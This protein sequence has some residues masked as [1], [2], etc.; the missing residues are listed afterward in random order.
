MVHQRQNAHRG[1]TGFDDR[2]THESAGRAESR[3]HEAIARCRWTF[4]GRASPAR[5]ASRQQ[6]GRR[7]P[8]ACMPGT[9]QSLRFRPACRI[10]RFVAAQG[11]V[12]KGRCPISRVRYF[13]RPQRAPHAREVRRVPDFFVPQKF[14]PS[15]DG[16][17]GEV[18]HRSFTRRMP[19]RRR[20]CRVSAQKRPA[21]VAI[22][23]ADH[24]APMSPSVAASARTF[25]A[26]SLSELQFLPRA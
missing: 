2:P 10:R 25:F 11:R 24:V 3:V 13:Y 14:G 15:A 6:R 22:A 8:E 18:V 19:P 23:K 16:R 26:D 7:C 9:A 17:V 21:R 5:C 12:G 1:L 4:V 20:L